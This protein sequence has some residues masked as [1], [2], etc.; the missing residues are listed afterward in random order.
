MVL[1]L[2]PQFSVEPLLSPASAAFYAHLLIPI[3]SN[4]L[5][6]PST[7]SPGSTQS[8]HIQYP[9]PISIPSP[10]SSSPPSFPLATMSTPI[11]SAPPT[12]PYESFITAELSPLR[13]PPGAPAS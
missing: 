3:P 10:S 12:K 11:P 4:P 2:R 7:H 1:S 5:D 13:Y 8:S 6:L 9:N